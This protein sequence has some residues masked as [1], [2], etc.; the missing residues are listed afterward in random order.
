VKGVL[1]LLEDT[2]NPFF[3][4]N[5]KFFFVTVNGPDRSVFLAK[6]RLFAPFGSVVR[7][8]IRLGLPTMLFQTGRG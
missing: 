1:R 8:G 2:R 4:K 7:T 6:I 5:Q 3:E